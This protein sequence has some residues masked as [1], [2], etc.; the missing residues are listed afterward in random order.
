MDPAHREEQEGAEDRPDNG[1][2]A[3]YGHRACRGSTR[4]GPLKLRRDDTTGLPIP[5]HLRDPPRRASPRSL[6]A[7]I[8]RAAADGLKTNS[9]LR[10]HVGGARVPAR[11]VAADSVLLIVASVGGDERRALHRSV[12][13]ETPGGPWSA[14]SGGPGRRRSSGW[15]GCWGFRSTRSSVF[16]PTA[17]P[18]WTGQLNVARSRLC[19]AP[20]ARNLGCLTSTSSSPPPCPSVRRQPLTGTSSA[21]SDRVPVDPLSDHRGYSAGRSA[22]RPSSSCSTPWTGTATSAAAA[23]G[24]TNRNLAHRC[25]RG[26]RRGPVVIPPVRHHPVRRV[27]TVLGVIHMLSVRA[28]PFIPQLPTA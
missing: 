21:V 20:C 13:P 15:H 5:T 17:R 19:P 26:G 4:A 12:R 27:L 8:G 10:I 18:A 16:V 25:P 3:R 24:T 11:A 14:C 2:A 22:R 28:G 23:S 1:G 7:L 6:P 9:E